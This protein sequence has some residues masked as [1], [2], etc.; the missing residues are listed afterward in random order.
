[1]F[2]RSSLNN[3][4]FLPLATEQPKALPLVCKC[5]NGGVC[6][7][8]ATCH[9]EVNYS[10]RYCQNEV[11]RVPTT[12]GSSPAAVVVPIFLIII[13]ILTAVGLYIYWRRKQGP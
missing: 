9:C 4:L 11:R 10:G 2:F 1:M 6:L 12:G 5:Q 8:D 3:I 7:D 13:V